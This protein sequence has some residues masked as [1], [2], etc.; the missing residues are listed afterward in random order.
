MSN[1]FQFFRDGSLLIRQGATA[2]V[3]ITIAPSNL[4]GFTARLEIARRYK[5]DLVLLLTTEN[6]GLVITPGTPN[7]AI[8]VIA[9]SAQTG[10][11]SNTFSG[12]YNLELISPSGF[13]ERTLE[14]RVILSTEV[15]NNP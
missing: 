4:T 10:A 8:Q 1:G 13:V 7:S 3:T 15:A 2:F 11:L 9:S 5:T 6:N 14:G 12:I